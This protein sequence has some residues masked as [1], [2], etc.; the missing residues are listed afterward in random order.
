MGLRNLAIEL[1]RSHPLARVTLFH[2]GTTDTALSKP[3]QHNVAPEALFSPQRAA[4]QFLDVLDQRPDTREAL[5]LDWA[6]RP[7]A[8]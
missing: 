6:G 1:A 2:P 4:A 3:F 8:Y 5:F 7:I